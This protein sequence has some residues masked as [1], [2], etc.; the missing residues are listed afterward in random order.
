M[1]HFNLKPSKLVGEIKWKIREA[2]LNGDIKNDFQEA[3]KYMIGI[4]KK[5]NL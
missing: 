4:G 2:I 5:M 1:K 3:E